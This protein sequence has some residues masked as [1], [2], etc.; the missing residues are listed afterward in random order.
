MEVNATHTREEFVRRMCGKCF[1]CGSIAHNK[2]DGNHKR[3]ICTY[4]HHVG[5]QDVVCLDK[6]LGKPKGQ[7]IAAMMEELEREVESLRL[8][9]GEFEKIEEVKIAATTSVTLTQLLEQQKQLSKQIS[10]WR[11]QD[12]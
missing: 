8:S 2:R 3:K 5:H 1:E 4:C 6:F 12:F 10:A 9:P 11:E 7:Q